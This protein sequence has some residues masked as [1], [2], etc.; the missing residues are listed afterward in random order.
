MKK[1]IRFIGIS[2][3]VILVSFNVYVF[4]SGKSYLYKTLVYNYVDID[5]KA[6]FHSREIKAGNGV[7]WPFSSSYN[8]KSMPDYLK[9]ELEVNKSVAFLVIKDDSILYENYWEQ[10]SDT[11]QSNSFSMAKSIIGVLTGIAIDE[12]KIKNLNQPVGD[13]IPE[14]K[15]GSRAQLTLRNL[16]TMSAAL[17]WD[18]EY[19]SL[20]SITTEAYYGRDLYALVAN[21]DVTG[22]PGKDF[23]YQSGCTELLAIVL[24]KA[25]GKTVSE[26]ASEKLWKPIQAMH[27]AD[28]SLDHKNG[29]E[30]AYC[31]F[32]S[33]ARDFARIGALYLHKGNWKGTQVVD[34][35]WVSE[36]IQPAP[37]LDEG[38]P[39][40]IYGY[41]WWL[42]NHSGKSIYYCR[43]LLGQ[44]IVVI[45]EEHIIFVRLGHKR[46]EKNAD[47]SLTDVPIYV[48]GVLDWVK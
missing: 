20:M 38:K 14:Y 23:N 28:W 4:I 24:E 2:I 1:A 12:G 6:I 18:E 7:E 34:S 26:Y 41:H 29:L 30:K 25:T 48:K 47:G 45:P 5:D 36:S 9:N 10:Y 3:L 15:T 33:N 39:N 44:Y 22:T 42:D 35:N 32:Y 40:R 21:I 27:S 16:I 37:L 17:N 19:S 43:G 11:S 31:C 8:K 13:F 46:A